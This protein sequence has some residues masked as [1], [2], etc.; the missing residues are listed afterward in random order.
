MVKISLDI[1][2]RSF[3]LIGILLVIILIGGFVI[4]YN[5]DPANPAVMGHSINE[6][7]LPDCEYGEALIKQADGSWGCG[8]AGVGNVNFTRDSF[9]HIH[10][11]GEYYTSCARHV[12]EN[13][14]AGYSTCIIDNV[15]LSLQG[16]DT[17]CNC[18][19]TCFK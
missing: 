1:S 18:S 15:E 8:S 12:N 16:H 11:T 19:R 3:I 5:T 10:D 13:I 2:N 17:L 6:I 4:A 7:N 14:P 9:N